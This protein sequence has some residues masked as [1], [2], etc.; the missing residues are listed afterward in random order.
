[1]LL[2]AAVL[3]PPVSTTAVGVVGLAWLVVATTAVAYLLFLRGLRPI[4]APTATTAVAGSN[5]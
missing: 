2:P 3:R 5:R 1:M 4:D